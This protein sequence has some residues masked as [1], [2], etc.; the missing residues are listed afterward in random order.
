MTSKKIKPTMN[1]PIHFLAFCGGAGLIP[2][3]PGTFGSLVGV[4]VFWLTLAAADSIQLLIAIGLFFTG[5]WLC[6]ESSKILKAH[7][8]PGI[9]WDEMAAMYAVL[10]F[11]PISINDWLLAFI[12]FRIFDI[13]KPWPISFLDKKVSGGLGIMLDD[14]AAGAATVFTCILWRFYF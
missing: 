10:I 9:V 5:I 7:D 8:H 13:W 2:L 1:S 11:Q 4:L 6:G 3:A 12:L 14:I